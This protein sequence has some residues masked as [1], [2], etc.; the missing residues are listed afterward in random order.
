[1]KKRYRGLTGFLGAVSVLLLLGGLWVPVFVSARTDGANL[2][3]ESLTFDS[4]GN[5]CMT[6]HDKKAEGGVRY[7]TIG[8]VVRRTKEA[9]GAGGVIRLKLEKEGTP[10][11]DPA[12]PDYVF[13]RL[14]CAAELI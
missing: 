1:M 9:E 6:T 4:R 5:L 2:Y 7:R 13:T 11:P 8:W 14:Q 12:N 3:E 10:Q